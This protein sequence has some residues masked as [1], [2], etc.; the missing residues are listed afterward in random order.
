MKVGK[1][2]GKLT[3]ADRLRYERLNCNSVASN[4]N[5]SCAD[6]WG[7]EHVLNWR[8]NIVHEIKCPQSSIQCMENELRDAFCT[9]QHAQIDFR[10]YIDIPNPKNNKLSKKF[11]PSFLTVDCPTDAISSTSSSS[12]L[13]SQ[14]SKFKEAFKFNHLYSSSLSSQRCDVYFN[15]TTLLYSHD[16]ILNFGHL[17][18]DVLNVW[19][20]LYLTN[21][22]EHSRH[23]NFLTVDAMKLYNNFHDQ[24]N[25][26]FHIY[27]QSFHRILRGE[28]F[29]NKVVCFE[30]LL[31]QPLP[32]RGFV[33][34]NW[35]QVYLSLQT[36]SI[37][38]N[39]GMVTG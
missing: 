11:Q 18:N 1:S 29:K 24:V 2:W 22:A 3:T 34:D 23:F 13:S 38:C 35:H 25:D 15:G 5:P 28:E 12:P 17:Y 14:L 27:K 20:M 32:S 33:W 36:P 16:N 10:K 9:F 19:L 7:D 37:P 26:F 30:K 31:L 6:A 21:S 39:D 4:T 8:K